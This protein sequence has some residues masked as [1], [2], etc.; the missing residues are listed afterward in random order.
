MKK[1]Q[2]PLCELRE[3]ERII[4]IGAPREHLNPKSRSVKSKTTVSVK[5]TKSKPVQ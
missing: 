5:D 4:G 1:P 3:D 2:K